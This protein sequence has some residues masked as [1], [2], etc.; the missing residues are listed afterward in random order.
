MADRTKAVTTA[1]FV[2]KFDLLK[3]EAGMNLSRLLERLR[4]IART[5][6]RKKSK[7]RYSNYNYEKYLRERLD[8]L[9]SNF[10]RL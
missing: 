9:Q 4:R 10:S 2:T 7:R 8:R 3:S 1:Y 5:L 6:S